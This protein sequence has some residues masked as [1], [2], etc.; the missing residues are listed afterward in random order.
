MSQNVD[1]LLWKI[2]QPSAKSY[3]YFLTV[4]SL[5]WNVKRFQ[6]SKINFDDSIAEYEIIHNLSQPP[7]SP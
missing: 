4:I 6:F 5:S 3:F 7:H 1:L 2:I